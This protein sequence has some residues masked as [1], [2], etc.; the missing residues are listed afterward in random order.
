MFYYAVIKALTLSVLTLSVTFKRYNG[1]LTWSVCDMWHSEGNTVV[2]VVVRF[3]TRCGETEPVYTSLVLTAYA[4]REGS[5]KN[6][7]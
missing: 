7:K 3:N 2:R 1:T 5:R 6:S 4:T